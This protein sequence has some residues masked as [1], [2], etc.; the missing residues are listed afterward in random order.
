MN[1][2][3]HSPRAW[4]G[5]LLAAL[6]THAPAARVVHLSTDQVFDGAGHLLARV[7]VNRLWYHYFGEGI[8]ATPN[9]FGFQGERPTDPELLDWLAVRLIETAGVSSTCT[10]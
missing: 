6:R 1:T 3:V 8:V 9:D 10:G 7:I 5:A 4:R 2:F